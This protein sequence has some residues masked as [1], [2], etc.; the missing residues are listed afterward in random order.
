MTYELLKIV[1][2]LATVIILIYV[3]VRLFAKRQPFVGPGVPVKNIGY[4]GLGPRRGILVLKAGREVLLLGITQTEIRLLR[5]YPQ[6]EFLHEEGPFEK[7]TE[8]RGSF[9]KLLQGGGLF[10]EKT[11]P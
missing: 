9:K 3:F 7:K 2:A 6:E 1:W 5:A 10:N 11:H 8:T 4:L